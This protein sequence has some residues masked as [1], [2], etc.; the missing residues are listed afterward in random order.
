MD[1]G[2]QIVIQSQMSK[3]PEAEGGVALWLVKGTLSRGREERGGLQAED[4]W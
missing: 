4:A 3:V 1:W 2:R